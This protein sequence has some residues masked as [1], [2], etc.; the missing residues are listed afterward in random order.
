[1][2]CDD[3]AA[4]AE[5]RRD[6][7]PRTR[8]AAAKGRPA[9]GKGR[10][11][12]RASEI[13]AGAI[14]K[15]VVVAALVVGALFL[16]WEIRAVIGLLLISIFFALAISPPVEW[17]DRHRVPRWLAIL[18]VYLGIGTAIVG[19]GLLIVPPLV[20]GI[21]DLSGDIPNYIEDLRQNDSFRD[22]DDRYDITSGL[23]TQATE[24][25]SRL[26]DAAG[27]LRDVTVGV[28]SSLV[29]LFSILVIT[30]FL[31]IEG[32]RVL[33]FFYRQMPPERKKRVHG[34]ADDI[35]NAISGYVFGAF[36]IATL[37]GVMTYVVL[38]LLGV[39]FAL[40]LAIVFAFFDLIPLLG[41]TI[42]G[43]VV[44]IVVAFTSFPV[45]FLIW[46]G[47]LVIYQ[48]I[49]NNLIVPHIYGQ[50]V[51]IHPLIVIVAILIGAA[52]LGILGALIAIPAAA[53]IQAVIKDYWAFSERNLAAIA[54]R[55]AATVDEAVIGD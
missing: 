33:Y 2:P 29:Q 41:A 16:L 18:I 3:S 38:S 35:S 5:R 22:Y 6:N 8:Q 43:I 53:A 21:D 49:E 37:A 30:F 36:V 45:G 25:P 51:Q 13:S 48:Q 34:V 12:V 7:R 17:L 39:P 23:E 52:L 28:F 47:V 54:A 46:A 26:G 11:A 24:L 14:A 27:T 42:G 10:N 9:R 32:R 40:P 55:A 4:A 44:G 1:M 19:V 20:E 15:V 50:A 31:L